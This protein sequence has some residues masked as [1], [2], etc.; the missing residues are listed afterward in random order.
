VPVYVITIGTQ[1]SNRV[2][3]NSGSLCSFSPLLKSRRILAL[4]L[5][6]PFFLQSGNIFFA[7]AHPLGVDLFVVLA[8]ER[9]GGVFWW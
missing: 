5:D 6:Y 1:N 2:N 9:R 7:V 3:R 4:G 8:E